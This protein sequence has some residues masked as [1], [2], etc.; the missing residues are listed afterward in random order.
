MW[1]LETDKCTIKMFY[2]TT[3]SG[4]TVTKHSL[5][6]SPY[7]LV[8]RHRLHLHISPAHI[9]QARYSRWD[10]TTFSRE[11]VADH[12][13][14]GYRHRCA[15]YSCNLDHDL[16]IWRF[17]RQVWWS[18][19]GVQSYGGSNFGLLHRNGLSPITLAQLCFVWCI[20]KWKMIFLGQS[21][22]KLQTDRHTGRC[23]WRHHQATTVMS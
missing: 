5:L 3:T 7:V 12:P 20:C 11:S 4:I 22:R 13:Q 23:D 10:N 8:S 6:M 18:V 14:T 2:V 16:V 9:K 21:F 1:S 19:Q 15:S 17:W